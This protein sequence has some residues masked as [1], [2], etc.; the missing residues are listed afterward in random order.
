MQVLLAL[1]EEHCVFSSNSRKACGEPHRGAIARMTA[2]ENAADFAAVA[3]AFLAPMPATARFTLG[4][5][6][7]LPTPLLHR[8]A[9]S[10]TL[11]SHGVNLSSIPIPCAAGV[12]C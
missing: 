6:C 4:D 10:C 12:L 7:T 1:S 9:H 3:S 8:C 11:S 5:V 2:A